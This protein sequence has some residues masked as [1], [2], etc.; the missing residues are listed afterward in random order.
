MHPVPSVDAGRVRAQQP[1]QLN[2]VGFLNPARPVRALDKV[3]SVQSGMAG[4]HFYHHAV[5]EAARHYNC[6]RSLLSVKT[7]ATISP[8]L[9]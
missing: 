3:M 8:I 2:A 1:G 9:S 5:E 4:A 7:M 6:P